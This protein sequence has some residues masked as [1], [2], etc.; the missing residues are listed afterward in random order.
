MLVSAETSHSGLLDYCQKQLCRARTSH[1]PKRN[2][3]IGSIH[4]GLVFW[5]NQEPLTKSASDCVLS[6]KPYLHIFR[7]T[8]MLGREYSPY[9]PVW[10]QTTISVTG[11]G[12]LFS[13]CQT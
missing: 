9:S 12:G 10:N 5:W 13:G 11:A 4:E 1:R 8:P 7:M 2:I 6:R 3:P